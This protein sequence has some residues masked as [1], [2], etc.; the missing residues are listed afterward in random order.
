MNADSDDGQEEGR[1][2]VGREKEGE[3]E[4]KNQDEYIIDRINTNQ[5]Q[6]DEDRRK[7]SGLRSKRVEEMVEHGT[8]S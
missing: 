7:E 2:T 3:N 8:S 4:D 6:K 1:K 5:K